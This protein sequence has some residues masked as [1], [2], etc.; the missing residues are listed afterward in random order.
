LVVYCVYGH[1][2]VFE[3][4]ETHRT[5]VHRQTAVKEDLCLFAH[6]EAFGVV[7]VANRKV[8]V[9]DDYLLLVG[10]GVATNRSHDSSPFFLLS[11]VRLE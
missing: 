1:F 8:I 9:F 11:V 6:H 5:V 4:L 7:D 10:L 3:Q 2:Y